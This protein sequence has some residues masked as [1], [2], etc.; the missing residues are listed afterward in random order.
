MEKANRALG[1]ISEKM[2]EFQDKGKTLPSF[3]SVGEGGDLVAHTLQAVAH[4]IRNPLMAVGGFAKKLAASL[5]PSSDGGKYVQVILAE[6][7]RLETA[8]A[9][10]SRKG[11]TNLDDSQDVI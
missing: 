4:E 2:T 1:D 6:A 7:T 5:D 8:L 9:D 11:G 10:M 3:E